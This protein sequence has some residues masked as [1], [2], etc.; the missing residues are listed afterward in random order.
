M[1]EKKLI[2][3]FGKP[4]A[5][6]TTIIQEKFAGEK[7]VDVKTYVV[8]YRKDGTVPE[9]KT[10][11]AYHDMYDYVRTL[12]D[13]TVVLELGTNHAEY[14]IQQLKVL[15]SVRRVALFLCN[16]SD[17]TLRERLQ[18]SVSHEDMEK[19]YVRL[20]RVFPDEHIKLLEAAGM[21]YVLLDMEQ[22]WT[23]NV[24]LISQRLRDL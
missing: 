11:D 24:I 15:Q 16:A 8:A 9:E 2:V 12:D 13:D 14:N 19:M 7:V 20:E 10:L 21:E 6:K 4:G 22:P 5:G 23:D 1:Q 18:N 3:F 17:E